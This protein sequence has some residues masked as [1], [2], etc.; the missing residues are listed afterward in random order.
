MAVSRGHLHCHA[1]T[2][3]CAPLLS[4]IAEVSQSIWPLGPLGGENLATSE[5]QSDLSEAEIA[6]HIDRHENV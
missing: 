5:E 2:Q 4:C 1:W 6:F 3:A